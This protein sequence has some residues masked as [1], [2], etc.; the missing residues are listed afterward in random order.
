MTITH[1][2]IRQSRMV[3]LV[4]TRGLADMTNGWVWKS[5]NLRVQLATPGT[6][7]SPLSP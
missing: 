5:A 7:C 2:S 3:V 4:D 6:K 1:L